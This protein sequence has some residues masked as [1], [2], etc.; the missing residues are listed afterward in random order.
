MTAAVFNLRLYNQLDQEHRIYAM[1]GDYDA[2]DP[3]TGA[4]MRSSR[5][6]RKFGRPKKYWAHALGITVRFTAENDEKAV[7]KANK[8]LNE[9][10]AKAE[11]QP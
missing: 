10:Y 6:R 4:Y 3:Q 1:L 11:A 5:G 2:Y 8:M 9:A 7:E